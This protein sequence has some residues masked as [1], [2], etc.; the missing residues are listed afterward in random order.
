VQDLGSKSKALSLT[1]RHGAAVALAR[2]RYRSDAPR[3]G[4]MVTCLAIVQSVLL[5]DG[6]V[7]LSTVSRARPVAVTK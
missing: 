7:T 2:W 6:L 4:N 1:F 5:S 3:G